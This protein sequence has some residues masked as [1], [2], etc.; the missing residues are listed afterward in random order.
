[1]HA[2]L[3]G[4]MFAMSGMIVG[5]VL[6]LLAV[7]NSASFT[8][9]RSSRPSLAYG[10]TVVV[11]AEGRG[12]TRAKAL[13]DAY[14][15]AMV[16]AIG[17]YVDAQS[18]VTEDEIEQDRVI[19]I[20][21]G[22]IVSCKV[23]GGRTDGKA[24][25]VSIRAEVREKTNADHTV[26]KVTVK[27]EGFGITED[28]ALR[29]AYRDAIIKA[30]GLYVDARS[31]MQNFQ[32]L[33]DQA[34][35]FDNG[36]ISQVRD[37]KSSVAEGIWTVKITADV[38][39]RNIVPKFRRVFPDA[40]KDV[41]GSA[42][43]IHAKIKSEEQLQ[44]E[45]ADL[46]T[47][48]LD[49]IDRMRDWTKLGLAAGQE[50]APVTM[51]SG[52]RMYRVRYSVR[53]DQDAYF[54]D[55]LPHF[56]QTLEK[57]KCGATGSSYL[58]R[59]GIVPGFQD[60]N[61][62]IK[63]PYSQLRIS[64]D[65]IAARR[66][67]DLRRP[68]ENI[69]REIAAEMVRGCPL[70]VGRTHFISPMVFSDYPGNFGVPDSYYGK[71]PSNESK[72]P[73][74]SDWGYDLW[75]VDGIG[76]Q[77]ALHCSAYNIPQGALA[78]YGRSIVKASLS[79]RKQAYFSKVDVA[80]LDGDGKVIARTKD[81][82]PSTLLSCGSDDPWG[83]GRDGQEHLASAGTVS[84]YCFASYFVRPFFIGNDSQ[85]HIVFASEIHRDVYFD[86]T[87]EQLAEVS[88]VKVRYVSGKK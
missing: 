82:L 52:K 9:K 25:V 8:L 34:E 80:L 48:A 29:G 75:L 42:V 27:A 86:L 79:E 6:P 73:F 16:K 39:R 84:Y 64:R 13:E 14:G 30:V 23:L 17:L 58:R 63:G 35:Q 15:N 1:M 61:P 10:R 87:D 47:A 50:F 53:V 11:I 83:N 59:D 67:M 28:E 12:A 66:R 49:G 21:N 5:G 26:P 51:T 54:K 56:K 70:Q 24:H 31:V 68:I 40:F 36:D 41:S 77:G 85:N 62:S 71:R 37:K 57:M 88:T 4:M 32:D 3:I 69:H 33:K 43:A 7:G 72:T 44:K 55:F 20:C 74:R 38:E 19:K 78:V 46:M 18:W 45:A 60:M 76:T 22:E 2:R 65:A 81:N